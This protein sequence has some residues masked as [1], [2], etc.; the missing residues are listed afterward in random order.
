[1]AKSRPIPIAIPANIEFAIPNGVPIKA[2]AEKTTSTLK[3][4]G[5]IAIKLN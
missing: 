3:T 1:M 4:T 2:K 5:M